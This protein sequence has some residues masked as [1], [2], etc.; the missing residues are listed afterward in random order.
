MNNEIDKNSK[1]REA[2]LLRVDSDLFYKI[3]D[4]VQK[5]KKE[6]GRKNY[7]FNKFVVEAMEEKMKKINKSSRSE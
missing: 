1:K 5:S 3:N 6:K 7:S 2:Y 4:Y